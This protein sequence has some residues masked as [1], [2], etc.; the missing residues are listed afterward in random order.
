METEEDVNNFI[1]LSLTGSFVP[2]MKTQIF[3]RFFQKLELK[4]EFF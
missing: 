4:I 2:V 1:S 3:S